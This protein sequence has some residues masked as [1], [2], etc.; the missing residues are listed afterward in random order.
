MK[1]IPTNNFK[2]LLKHLGVI[3][4]FFG[5]LFFIFFYL[6]LPYTTQHGKSI[7][8]PE[9]TDL[10]TQEAIQLLELQ[11]LNYE[12]TDSIFVLN[13]KANVVLS[14]YPEAGDQVKSNRRIYI[15]ISTSTPPSIKLPN[16]I[17]SSINSA[18]QQLMINGLIKGE[19]KEINDPRAKEVLEIYSNGKLLEEGSL[20]KK[21]SRIDLV[22]GNGEQDIE[23][24]IP[25]LIGKPYYEAQ[26]I[27]IGLN[28]KIGNI[29]FDP[30]SNAPEG[31]IFRQE[32]A[33]CNGKSIHT[34]D[35]IHIWV[36]G[37]EEE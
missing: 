22:I 8:V 24:E 29:T 15:T 18:E 21:G 2:D 33:N 1:I 11:D 9:V 19:V 35:A 10:D 17:G 30:Y 32:C 6:F 13:K 12:I 28:L 37:E 25:N 5:V 27:L 31:T 16:I 26:F 23:M 4:L 34:G 14:Q 36:S 7:Q 3:I 20:I